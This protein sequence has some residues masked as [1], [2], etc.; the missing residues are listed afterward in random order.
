MTKESNTSEWHLPALAPNLG[1]G[2]FSLGAKLVARF[3]DRRQTGR[4]IP[5]WRV[6]A[7]FQCIPSKQHAVC[8]L[9]RRAEL[10]AHR[11][12]SEDH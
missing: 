4:Q 1:G 7:I 11:A 12:S 3:L 5:G 10:L 2:L 9:Y 6:V 8:L